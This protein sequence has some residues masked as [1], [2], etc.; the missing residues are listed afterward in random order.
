MNKDKFWELI[1]ETKEECEY[2]IAEMANVL[3]EKLSKYSLEEMQKFSGILKTYK[4]A[5]YRKGVVSIAAMMNHYMLSDDGFNDFRNWLIAQGKEVYMQTMK[6]PE[7]LAI[8][9]VSSIGGWYEFERFGYVPMNAIEERTGNYEDAFVLLPENE[10]N[11]I[12]SEI[13]FGE[14][15]DLDLSKEDI[16]IKYPKFAEKFGSK[17]IAFV[18]GEQTQ[19]EEQT[20]K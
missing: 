3:K 18:S 1:N 14:Y 7:V 8:K 13:E 19:D 16:K 6:D 4:D 10:K 5:A 12:L 11:E 20:M 2:N 9:P 15:I 17:S